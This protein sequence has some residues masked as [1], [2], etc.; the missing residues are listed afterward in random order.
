MEGRRQPQYTPAQRA[1]WSASFI[2]AALSWWFYEGPY[3]WV[4]ELQLRLFNEY[5]IVITGLV[6]WLALALPGVFLLRN[7]GTR[8]LPAAG[9]ARN[10]ASGPWLL[11]VPVV[12]IAGGGA[13]S[14]FSAHV[15]LAKTTADDL[16]WGRWPSSS[17]AEI[18]G[19][20]LRDAT[21]C[22]G[23]RYSPT[24]YT[25]LVS[26][27]WTPVVGI[28]AFVESHNGE[29][30]ES[31]SFAGL[32]SYSG[33]PGH[34]RAVFERARLPLKPG[35]VVIELGSTPA[36]L[37]LVGRIVVGA[38]VLVALLAVAAIISDRRHARLLQKMIAESDAM[39]TV[40]TTG[41]REGSL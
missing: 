37:D 12:I 17:W 22:G 4:A 11:A 14:W 9:A 15:S 16:E 39:K 21:V 19:R 2:L 1:W 20:T 7:V 25:P 31:G 10:R 23:D 27:D 13:L 3:R 34:I 32:R 41:P 24:C 29:L 6:A 18:T 35:F 36:K 28:A 26:R 38:G 33:M 5:E 40:G 30:P 8:S